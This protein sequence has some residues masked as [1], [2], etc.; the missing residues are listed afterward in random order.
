MQMD[1]YSGE[2]TVTVDYIRYFPREV[3]FGMNSKPNY[4][5]YR[6]ADEFKVIGNIYEHSE[7]LEKRND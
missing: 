2:E 5:F 6:Y 4:L 7:L 3:A 1:D